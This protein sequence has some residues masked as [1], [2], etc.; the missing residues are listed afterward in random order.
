MGEAEVDGSGSEA[1]VWGCGLRGL[2]EAQDLLRSSL[3]WLLAGGPSSFLHGS[4][5]PW[6]GRVLVSCAP[7]FGFQF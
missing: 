5:Q 7:G 2:T 3:M 4:V 1:A 6:G